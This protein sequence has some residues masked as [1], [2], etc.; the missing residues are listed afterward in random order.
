VLVLAPIDARAQLIATSFEELPGA[1]QP[2]ETIQV[3]TA[4]G[5]RLKGDVL[6]VSPSGLELRIRTPRP[7]GNTAAVTQRR[8]VENDVKQIVREHRDSLWNGTMIGLAAAALPGIA[9]IAWG[10]SAANDGYTTGAEIAGAGTSSCLASAREWAR[11]STHQSTGAPP[12]TSAC[13]RRAHHCSGIPSISV[14]DS[15]GATHK[16]RIASLSA[17]STMLRRCVAI[18]CETA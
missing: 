10:L 2:G 12:C 5:N 14:T 17:T 8:F 9:T 18:R 4:S 13:P 3:T 6:A 11:P 7:D 15:A 1:L 16:G